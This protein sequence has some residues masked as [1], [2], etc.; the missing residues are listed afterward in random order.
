MISMPRNPLLGECALFRLGAVMCMKTG[1][2]YVI[3]VDD[4]KPI[5]RAQLAES[6]GTQD[7]VY[8]VCPKGQNIVLTD[9][10]ISDHPQVCEAA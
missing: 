10:C 2:F 6:L 9:V 5:L 1:Q 3:R 4:L 8:L 7:M